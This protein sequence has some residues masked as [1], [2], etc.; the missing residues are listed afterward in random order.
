[1]QINEQ[2]LKHEF[3]LFYSK[4]QKDYNES[5]YRKLILHVLIC[6]RN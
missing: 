1:M 5:Q 4:F 6:V 3:F 2:L